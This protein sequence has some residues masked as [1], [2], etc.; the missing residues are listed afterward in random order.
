MVHRCDPNKLL[1]EC[2]CTVFC[3]LSA[4]HQFD[5]FAAIKHACLLPG[6]VNRKEIFAKFDRITDGSN[7]FLLVLVLTTKFEI[8]RKEIFARGHPVDG[9]EER[10]MM[11][12]VSSVI[13]FFSK[14]VDKCTAPNE[15][16]SPEKVF[17]LSLQLRGLLLVCRSS[18]PSPDFILRVQ[19]TPVQQE[20]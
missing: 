11:E 13:T 14:K 20:I 5:H 12:N 16:C 10:H 1:C 17:R 2:L 6:A 8:R 7:A 9:E 18:A 19:S 3:V 15:P 4:C